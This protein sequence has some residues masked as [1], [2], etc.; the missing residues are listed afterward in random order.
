MKI[1]RHH[2]LKK[3]AAEPTNNTNCTLTQVVGGLVEEEQMWCHEAELHEDHA[4]LLT[5]REIADGQGVCVAL[6]TVLACAMNWR[7]EW[8]V[9]EIEQ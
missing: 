7:R 5:T 3:T 9:E 2:I 8:R 1:N 4:G 6:Q